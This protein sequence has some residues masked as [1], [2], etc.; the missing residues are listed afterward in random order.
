[1]FINVPDEIILY[2]ITFG[3]FKSREF[4]K[5][6]NINKLL[7]GLMDTSIT[8]EKYPYLRKESLTS[9]TVCYHQYINNLTKLREDADREYE[10][11]YSNM[12]IEN[13]WV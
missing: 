10:I 9:F 7:K 5:L 12:L 3:N 1:M 4:I 11:T 2:I 6:R 8:L 13:G